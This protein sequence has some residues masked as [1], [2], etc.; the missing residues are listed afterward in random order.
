MSVT[1]NDFARAMLVTG[2]YP[3]ANNNMLALVSWM[4]LEGGHYHNGARYNPLNTT[5]KMPGSVN[6]GFSAGVQ[7]YTDWKQGL[8]AT[9]KTLNYGA[10]ANIRKAL[11]ANAPAHQTLDIIGQ[12]PWGTKN[13]SGV[14]PAVYASYGSTPDPVGG[15]L[16]VSDTKTKA[17]K[18]AG[19]AMVVAGI[20]AIGYQIKQRI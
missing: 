12:T 11:S 6:P 9:I 14:D 3:V 17:M 18:V 16:N 19:A 20:A 8:D 5:Q 4:A 2:G 7:A 1:P 15:S 13:Y 10:Y